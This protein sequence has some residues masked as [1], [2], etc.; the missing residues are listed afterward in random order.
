MQDAVNYFPIPDPQAASLWQ[1]FSSQVRA[2]SRDCALSFDQGDSN[3]FMTS[4]KEFHNAD[5][6]LRSAQGRISEV[7][8]AS[9]KSAANKD[10]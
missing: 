10:R 4:L 8:R 5:I 2:G 6:A 3:R 7:R 1:T 9:G